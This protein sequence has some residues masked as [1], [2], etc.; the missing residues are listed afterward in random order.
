MVFLALPFLA[1]WQKILALWFLLF[2][3][4]GFFP[5]TQTLLFKSP[6]NILGFLFLNLPVR[7]RYISTNFTFSNSII[8]VCARF[9]SKFS[10]HGESGQNY[11]RKLPPFLFYCSTQRVPFLK[12]LSRLQ[13]P[14][15]LLYPLRIKAFL[16]FLS[17]WAPSIFIILVWDWREW[18][19]T[20]QTLF[21]VKV[22][23]FFNS[24]WEK[25]FI[26]KLANVAT[27]SEQRYDCCSPFG[28]IF[29]LSNHIWMSISCHEVLA[30]KFFYHQL[31]AML[32]KLSTWFQL[33]RWRL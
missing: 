22:Q 3:P 6:I 15:L 4:I 8:Q 30:Q 23:I 10:N 32:L 11:H 20:K 18:R 24:K 25:S 13:G 17:G 9:C 12:K 2:W 7:W 5:S 33:A 21:F 1:F 26:C 19:T 16:V 31:D 28:G 29:S 14:S 27:T